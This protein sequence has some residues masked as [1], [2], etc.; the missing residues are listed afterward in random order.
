MHGCRLQP[1]GIVL[2]YMH[3]DYQAF[4]SAYRGIAAYVYETVGEGHEITVGDILERTGHPSL[5][6][7]SV[8]DLWVSKE[9]IQMVRTMGGTDSDTVWHVS[10]LLEEE[11]QLNNGS[12]LSPDRPGC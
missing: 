10:P 12:L 9:L 2:G 11:A 8:L 4:D 7:D 5:L 6:V 3:A 1:R